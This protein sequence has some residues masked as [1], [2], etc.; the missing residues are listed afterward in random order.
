MRWRT[1]SR[2]PTAYPG[3]VFSDVPGDARS[4]SRPVSPAVRAQRGQ[5][6]Q[7]AAPDETIEAL[8]RK[9]GYSSAR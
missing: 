1:H 2:L 7:P 8:L 4:P 9:S 3:D 5:V 6:L